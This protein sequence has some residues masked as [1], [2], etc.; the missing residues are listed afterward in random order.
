MIA[1]RRPIRLFTAVD[2]PLIFPF[3]MFIVGFALVAT[4]L[5]VENG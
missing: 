3:E 4:A 5:A 2:S 1:F